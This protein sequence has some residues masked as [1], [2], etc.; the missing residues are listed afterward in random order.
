MS[1]FN[2]RRFWAIAA[3][4]L[5]VVMLGACWA[6]AH[7][8]PWRGKAVQL[9]S[10]KDLPPLPD[11]RENGWV[12]IHATAAKLG[13]DEPPHELREALDHLEWT[14]VKAL[15]E[16]VRQFA[17]DPAVRIQDAVAQNALASRRFADACAIDLDAPCRHVKV[18]RFHDLVALGV[19]D[20]ALTGNWDEAFARAGRLL[21][22]DLDLVRTT[23]TALSALAAQR[24]VRK[25]LSLLGVLIDG[26]ETEAPARL[27][28]QRGR[29]ASLA[30]LLDLAGEPETDVK[31]AVIAEYVYVTMAVR[32]ISRSAGSRGHDTWWMPLVLD[33][34]STV[35]LANTYF[36]A[37]MRFGE[38]PSTREAPTL[39]VIS[40]HRF[41][42]WAYNAAGKM[43]LD[44]SLLDLAPTIRDME[45]QNAEIA[46]ARDRL[47]QRVRILLEKLP[48][49]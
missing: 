38:S 19:L 24:S 47:R 46:V 41:G 13:E 17:G 9:W 15:A 39:P 5:A 26:I 45:K 2:K 3:P 22:A 36:E 33:E 20:N 29:V 11:E 21:R 49:E 25:D 6:V 32:T 16:R 10:E 35:A 44:A 43:T 12:L 23:R 37:L 34:E 14:R 8:I 30:T 4:L 1:T 31:R 48:E 28:N 27:A 40:R 18:M 42:W 7:H